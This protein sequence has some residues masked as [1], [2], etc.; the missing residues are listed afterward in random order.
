MPNV[1]VILP[2]FNAADTLERCVNAVLAQPGADA[3]GLRVIAVDN[4]STDA[5]PDILRRLADA[6]PR[7]TALHEP[8]QGAYAARNRGIAHLADSGEPADLLVFTDPD[9]I[10]EPDWLARLLA[11]LAD[12]AVE[13]VMGRDRH[14]GEGLAIRLLSAYDDAKERYTLASSDP[15]I[16]YGHTN[17]LATRRTTLDRVGRFDRRRRGADVL[18]VQR[19]IATA[20]TGTDAV[21]Y[22][23]DAVVHHL[24][25]DSAAGYFRK[26]YLYGHSNRLYQ[27]AI[28]PAPGTSSQAPGGAALPLSNRQRLAVFHLARRVHDI[29]PHHAALLFTL[30]FAGVGW[31]YAGKLFGSKELTPDR[32]LSAA[33]TRGARRPGQEAPVTR[34]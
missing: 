3:L 22:A 27:S 6:D 7:V 34:Q 29:P 19:V 25:V 30:L 4:N 23:P 18:F 14:A 5:S 2:V 21:V 10:A 16:Y 15:R 13:V 31:W 28:G 24:E 12:P 9:C 17:N 1:A 8:E 11:P 33:Q 20:D 32:N 26:T